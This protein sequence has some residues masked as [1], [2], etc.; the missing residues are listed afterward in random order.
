MYVVKT[1]S[2]GYSGLQLLP[3]YIHDPWK[4]RTFC[5][6][7]KTQDCF[8]FAFSNLCYWILELLMYPV[9]KERKTLKLR[10]EKPLGGEC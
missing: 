8:I 9:C 10:I 1:T 2:T 6:L 4:K 5:E 7:Y 3:S